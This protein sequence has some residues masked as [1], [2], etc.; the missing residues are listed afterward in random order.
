MAGTARSKSATIAR[1]ISLP[2]SSHDANRHGKEYVYRCTRHCLGVGSVTIDR[3]RVK[4]G[5]R[6]TATIG[7]MSA[8]V[9]LLTFYPDAKPALVDA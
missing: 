8:L 4:S 2:S 7:R 3:P 9:A 6:E 1:L 5:H